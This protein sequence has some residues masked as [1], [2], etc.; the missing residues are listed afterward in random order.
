MRNK[1]LVV[2][3]T[4]GRPWAAL[5]AIASVMKNSSGLADLVYCCDFDDPSEFRLEIPKVERRYGHRRSFAQWLN[6]VVRA[7]VDEY[8]WF[9][10]CADDIRY[11]TLDWDKKV[12][13]HAEM[14]VYGPDGI[15]DERM[16][17]HPFFRAC[18]PK[19]LGYVA[20]PGL[21]HGCLD[22]FIQGVAKQ[23]DSL[24]YNP[25]IK[26]DHL[27]HSVG[28]SPLDATYRCVDWSHDIAEWTNNIKPRLGYFA[29]QVKGI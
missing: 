27:H 10:W 20:P 7:N 22:V 16:A 4:R 28:R 23:L 6:Q 8:E 29:Q 25:E 21:L 5:E 14:V 13:E 24:A 12:V 19:S 1:I 11:L 17:T 3:P 18:L 26:M 15:H 2:M 9:T